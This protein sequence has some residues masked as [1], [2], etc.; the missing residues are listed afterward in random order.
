M[1]TN[2]ALPGSCRFRMY[3]ISKVGPKGTDSITDKQTNSL[4]HTPTN[5]PLYIFVQIFLLIIIFF[6]FLK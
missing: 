6:L 2:Y 5:T 3:V 4:T 1:R